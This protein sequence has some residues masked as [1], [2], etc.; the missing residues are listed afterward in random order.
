M[1]SRRQTGGFKPRS[2]TLRVRTFLPAEVFGAL[3]L[4]TVFSPVRHWTSKTS[5]HCHAFRAMICRWQ[6]AGDDPDY[7]PIGRGRSS[8]VRRMAPI[9]RIDLR[10][11]VSTTDLMSA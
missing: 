4:A 5:L 2:V 8:R 11:A 3:V 1:T 6:E 9:A 10:R 7:V